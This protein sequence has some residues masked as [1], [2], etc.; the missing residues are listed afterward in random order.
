MA[1]IA[2]LEGGLLDQL[3]I[4]LVVADRRG[5]VARWNTV[6]EEVFGW[7]KTE[8]LGRKVFALAGPNGD[9]AA[10]RELI[11]QV[12]SGVRWEGELALCDKAGTALHVRLRACPDRTHDDVVVG[13]VMVALDVA[14]AASTVA[15]IGA[16]IGARLAQA[17][18]QAGLTQKA[19]AESLGVTRR[20][21]QGYEAGTVVPYKHFDRLGELLGRT[22]ASFL[23][24]EKAQAVTADPIAQLRAAI[25]EELVAVFSELGASSEQLH[26]AE[27]AAERRVRAG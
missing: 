26:R 7:G 14:E 27:L 25:H 13:V 21:I 3:P 5:T 10:L 18:K 22:A 12:S 19:L 8:V 11:A 9:G 16:E 24:G 1:A 15:T 20:S 17:R 4:G 23:G 2:S 6:A